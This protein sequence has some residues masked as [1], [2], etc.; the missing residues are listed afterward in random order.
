MD[1][2]A[3]AIAQLRKDPTVGQGFSEWGVVSGVGVR[4]RRGPIGVM[5][6]LAPFNYVRWATQCRNRASLYDHTH[7]RTQAHTQSRA[8]PVRAGDS[9]SLRIANACTVASAQPLNEMYAMLIP[10]LLMG[11]VAV[12]KLPAIGGL[13]HVLTAEAFAQ[14]LPPGALNFVSGSGRQ[15]MGPIMESG[16]VD[17]LGFIG[18]VKGA[19]RRCVSGSTL[20]RAARAARASSGCQSPDERAHHACPFG[21]HTPARWPHACRML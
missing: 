21:S 7:K 3:A 13:V 6:G 11:N 4:V 1:F 16:K 2:I 8:G 15:T 9:V 20:S 5:L 19:V 18:G 17:V 12:L 10:S 14:H